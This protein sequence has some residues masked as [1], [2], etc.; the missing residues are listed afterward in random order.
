MHGDGSHQPGRE[1]QGPPHVFGLESYLP[2]VMDAKRRFALVQVL[3]LL[4][5]CRCYLPGI[6]RHPANSSSSRRQPPPQPSACLLS[7]LVCNKLLSRLGS[8]LSKCMKGCHAMFKGNAINRLRTPFSRRT[9]ASCGSVTHLYVCSQ[10]HGSRSQELNG[11]PAR[12][13]GMIGLEITNLGPPD[14]PDVCA[15]N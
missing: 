9:E 3:S 8:A 7:C 14:E 6:C 15:N 1:L 13:R 11:D 10:G 5:G 4:L 2:M 12:G